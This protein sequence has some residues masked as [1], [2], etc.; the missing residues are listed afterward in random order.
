MTSNM[1]IPLFP[2]MPLG[3]MHLGPDGV[4]PTMAGPA[5]A[6][7]GPTNAAGNRGGAAS[8]AGPEAAAAAGAGADANRAGQAIGLNIGTLL[9]S[10]FAGAGAGGGG[11]PNRPGQSLIMID[12]AFSG[13]PTARITL[14]LLFWHVVKLLLD[15]LSAVSWSC[16]SD[17]PCTYSAQY[18]PECA[19]TVI[20]NTTCCWWQ[21]FAMSLLILS[22]TSEA[23][24]KVFMCH[25]WFC[26]LSLLH[27]IAV[28]STAVHHCDTFTAV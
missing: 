17:L 12:C 10:A 3:A 9:Q 23:G 19:N 2:G 25:L 24:R 11:H 15:F 1:S 14:L 8:N 7:N 21:S 28:L 5:P 22:A 4:R 6:A 20:V 18:E 27:N 26:I 13:R 16:F